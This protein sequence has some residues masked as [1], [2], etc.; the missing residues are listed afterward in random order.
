MQVI[1]SDSEKQDLGMISLEERRN[2]S[3]MLGMF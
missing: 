2:K 1:T 3:D